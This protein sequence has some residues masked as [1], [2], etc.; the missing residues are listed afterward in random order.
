MRVRRL[1]FQG[2]YTLLAACDARGVPVL[3]EFL[4]GL[5]A[6]LENDADH[7]LA[8]L[9]RVVVSGPPRNTDVSHKIR[10]EIWE[11]IK[12]RLRVFWFYDEGRVIVCSHGLLKKTQKVPAGEL[13]RA[14]QTRADYFAAKQAG[15]LRIEEEDDD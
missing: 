5:G 14:E 4:K 11:F 1:P 12:G 7:L 3:L 6:N 2:P 9:E 15:R 8:L 13:H 10:G